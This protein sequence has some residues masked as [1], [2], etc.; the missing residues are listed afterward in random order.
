MLHTGNLSNKTKLLLGWKWGKKN[1]DGTLDD[2]QWQAFMDRM[3][4][5]GVITER[6]WA[7]VQSVW[8]LLEETKPGAQRAHHAMYGRY[9]NEITAD[10]VVTPFGTLRGGY[11][12]ALTESYFVQDAMLRQGEDGL[13][14]NS[15]SQMFPSTGNG[16]TKGREENYT[17][18]LSLELGLL[19]A[20][21]D[22]V[23]KFTHL[24]P[25]V[26]Q[27]MRLLKN[28]KLAARL[29]AFDP[30]A[31]TDLLLPWLTEDKG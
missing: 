28:R 15:A 16:F 13:E 11:V 23:V 24:G 4:R 26:R 18:P 5:E 6:D 22:K 17:Q 3:H 27:A 25:A 30:T 1:E 7:F 2:T 12:P 20:H 19:P 14:S 9:F 21:L 31:Q 10:P 8:D 29:K